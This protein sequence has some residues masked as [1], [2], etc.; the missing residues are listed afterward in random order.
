MVTAFEGNAKGISVR[1]E[2]R[3]SQFGVYDGEY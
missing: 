1:A 2:A 3:G